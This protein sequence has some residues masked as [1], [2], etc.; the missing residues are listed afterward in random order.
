MVIKEFNKYVYKGENKMT[1]KGGKSI[2]KV[3]KEQGVK[4]V[5]VVSGESFLDV[6]DDLYEDSNIYFV[7]GLEESGVSFMAKADAKA[8]NEIAV[9]MATR[10]PGTMNLSAGLHTAQQDSTPLVAL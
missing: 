7:S 4:K 2:V 1:H 10:V 8:T 5:F 6:L 9:C 3:L